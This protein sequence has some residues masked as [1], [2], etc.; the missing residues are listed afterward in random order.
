MTTKEL[1]LQ[2]LEQLPE[3]L[4]KAVLDFLIFLR[5]KQTQAER[6]KPWMQFMGT[7]DDAETQEIQALL[8]QEFKQFD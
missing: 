8:N 4:L 7:L 5:P 1:I 6:D 2:E 3:T